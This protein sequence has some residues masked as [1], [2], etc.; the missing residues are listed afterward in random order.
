MG[1]MINRVVRWV[2]IGLTAAA[3]AGACA[4][5]VFVMRLPEVGAELRPSLEEV[6]GKKIYEPG[7]SG[8][9]VLYPTH[10]EFPGIAGGDGKV[11]WMARRGLWPV[12][13]QQGASF[14]SAWGNP[15]STIAGGNWKVSHEV[16]RMEPRLY[17]HYKPVPKGTAKIFLVGKP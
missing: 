5:Y 8:F 17:L 7:K 15:L 1:V 12:Q 3:V 13:C 14:N 11:T 16:Y 6:Q 2:T 9:W 10:T 4:A